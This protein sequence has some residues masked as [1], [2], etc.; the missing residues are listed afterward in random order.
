LVR[1]FFNGLNILFF[2]GIVDFVSHFYIPSQFGE[3]LD[4]EPIRRAKKQNM[5]YIK[6]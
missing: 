3:Y 4:L 2:E 1:V 6:K 5:K